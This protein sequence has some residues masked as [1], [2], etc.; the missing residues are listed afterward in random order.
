VL[1]FA[2]VFG[3]S[4]DYE[5][6]LISRIHEEWQRTGD[7]NAAVKQGLGS[8]G[9]VTAAAAAVMIVV[10]VSFAVSSDNL[11]KLIGLALAS[12]VLLDALVIRT[13]L[14]PATLTLI[15]PRAWWFPQWLARR[16]PVVAVEPTTPAPERTLQPAVP[17]A[18]R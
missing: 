2:I 9:R 4:M 7:H 15:G 13:L 10:F 14:L 6:F 3:L 16:L 17:G 18:A 12:A 8:S 11:L 1:T 5:V